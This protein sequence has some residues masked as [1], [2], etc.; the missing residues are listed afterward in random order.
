MAGIRGIFRLNPNP[1][2]MN[3]HPA[4]YLLTA[5]APDLKA[6]FPILYRRS[7]KSAKYFKQPLPSD[8]TLEPGWQG[9]E[10]LP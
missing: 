9:Q 10:D 7:R 6:Q 4:Q 2:N 5:L 3:L 8:R 1:T